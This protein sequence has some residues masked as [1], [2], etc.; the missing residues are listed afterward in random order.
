ME[1]NRDGFIPLGE[2]PRPSILAAEVLMLLALAGLWA[3]SL[4]AGA[5][6]P[7]PA[8]EFWANFLYYVPFLLLPMAIYGRRRRGLSDALRL[9]PLPVLP[10]LM[11]AFMAVLSVYAASALGSLWA[12]LLDALGLKQ[13]QTSLDTLTGSGLLVSV[14]TVAAIP[15]VCEELLFR[16]LVFAAFERRG[17]AAG[18]AVSS[19]LF[20]LLHGNLYGLP[21]YV[22]V[23][24]VSAFIV[25]AL[26][27]LY[28]G[29]FYH[30]VYNT[31]ILVILHLIDKN[32]AATDTASAAS[33][34]PAIV[35]DLLMTGIALGL[36]LASLNLRRRMA[37]IDALPR[38]PGRMSGGERA[39]MI[40]LIV[41]LVAS[42]IA[43]QVISMAMP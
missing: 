30:T 29:M 9:N 36:M 21:G 28:A 37:G 10:M 42:M 19:V 41:G 35:T 40:V 26:D 12:M 5:L 6:L 25:F 14:L 38:T 34:L 27:S 8:Q 33:L 11:V 24:A 43:I 22:L 16:G 13:P 1:A 20:G 17:T 39:L 7:A 2:R 15:A 18:I 4:I 31:A 23:G 3:S 32:A